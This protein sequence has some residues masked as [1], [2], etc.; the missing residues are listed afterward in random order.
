MEVTFDLNEP[1]KIIVELDRDDGLNANYGSADAVGSADIVGSIE[2]NGNVAS[3]VDD[4][5]GVEGSDT[6]SGELAEASRTTKRQCGRRT[7]LVGEDGL[8]RTMAN[9]RT[10]ESGGH[11]AGK[12]RWLGRLRCRR[13]GSAAQTISEMQAAGD[14]EAKSK[15][16]EIGESQ[17]LLESQVEKGKMATSEKSKSKV[18]PRNKVI[19]VVDAFQLIMDTDGWGAEIESQEFTQ[20]TEQYIHDFTIDLFG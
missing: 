6:T 2:N 18:V 1:T 13:S 10:D 4:N 12:G 3:Y 20:R 15:V 8:V 7:S 17:P 19:E 14:A 9:I 11:R 16:K 5:D